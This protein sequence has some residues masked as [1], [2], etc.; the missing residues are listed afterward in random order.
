MPTL[1]TVPAL[2]AL[3]A[4]GSWQIQRLY[5]KAELIDKLQERSD[6]APVALPTGLENVEAF[7]FRRVVVTGEFLHEPMHLGH[8]YM[9][10]T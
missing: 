5:W 9:I 2:I 4:L 6:K 7:E 3:I 10:Y 1:F 8:S